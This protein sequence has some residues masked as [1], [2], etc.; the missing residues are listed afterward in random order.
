MSNDIYRYYNQGREQ[1]R[2]MRGLGKLEWIRTQEIIRRYLPQPPAAIYDVGGGAGNYAPW[3]A[4]LGYAVHLVDVIP[5]HIEQAL[6]SAAAQPDHPLQSAQVGDALELDFPD[7]S[8]DVV[9]LLGPLYHLPERSDRLQ[10][11]REAFRVL[12]ASGLLIAATISRFASLI[13]GLRAGY[14]T[15]DQFALLVE[16]D[17][18]DGRHRNPTGQPG[19][20]TTAYFHHPAEIREELQGAGFEVEA[21]LAVE[22]LASGLP[23]IDVY[24]SN[25]QLRERLLSL[26]RRVESEPTILGATGHMLAVGRKR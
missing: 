23:D 14:L 17:L 22:G 4:K 11:L 9:L 19:Y 21:V 6:E 5:L 7:A 2:L 18:T 20:F 26:L 13:D 3:L 8:A 10:A 24:W 12:K 1:A 25:D 16:Q 15:D